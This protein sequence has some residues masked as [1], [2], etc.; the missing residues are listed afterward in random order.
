MEECWLT[1]MRQEA[2]ELGIGIKPRQQIIRYRGDHA[3]LIDIFSGL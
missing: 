1:K 3:T 2:A